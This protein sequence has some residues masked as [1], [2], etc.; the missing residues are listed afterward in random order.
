MS[1]PC[2]GAPHLSA[3]MIVETDVSDKRYG[4]ILKQRLNDKE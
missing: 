2:L 1:L 4:G 3:F